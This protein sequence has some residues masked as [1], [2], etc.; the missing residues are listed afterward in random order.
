MSPEVIDTVESPKKIAE[1]LRERYGSTVLDPK[2]VYEIPKVDNP[3]HYMGLCGNAYDGV[4]QKLRA[5]ISAG[6]DFFAVIDVAKVGLPKSGPAPAYMEGVAITHHKPGQ[7]AELVGF[8]DKNRGSLGVGRDTRN[9]Y[10]ARMSRQHFSV[11]LTADGSVAIHDTSSNGTEVFR[12]NEGEGYNSLRH[13]D[14]DNPIDEREFWSVKS[15]YLKE[16]LEETFCEE[17]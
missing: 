2:E 7:R 14:I 1:G 8:I 9:G 12:P 3:D 16:K 11:G 15:M 13:T 4:D 10:S 5:I 6:D 17:E